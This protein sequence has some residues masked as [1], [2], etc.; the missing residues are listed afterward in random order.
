MTAYIYSR[1]FDRATAKRGDIVEVTFDISFLAP[2]TQL[3]SGL[4][5]WAITSAVPQESMPST[6]MQRVQPHLPMSVLLIARIT[7]L[8]RQPLVEAAS[9]F[10]PAAPLTP[11]PPVLPTTRGSRLHPCKSVASRLPCSI[12]CM[13]LL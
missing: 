9:A 13:P 1:Y 8:E 2:S 10:G 4:T 5:M 12:R 7:L 3:T 6:S 11:P